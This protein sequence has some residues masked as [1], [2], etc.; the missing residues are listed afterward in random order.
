MARPCLWNP[1][2]EADAAALA[3]TVNADMYD[4]L[5]AN[6]L[7]VAPGCVEPAFFNTAVLEM[8]FIFPRGNLPVYETVEMQTPRSCSLACRWS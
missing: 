2:N 4:P 8:E 1:P 5:T 3:R 7:H 6:K